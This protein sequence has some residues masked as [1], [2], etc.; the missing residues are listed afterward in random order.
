MLGV[1]LLV[2]K[3]MVLDL[4]PAS[5]EAARARWVRI[6]AHSIISDDKKDA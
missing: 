5:D 2:A 1:G 6:S 4:G 3:D